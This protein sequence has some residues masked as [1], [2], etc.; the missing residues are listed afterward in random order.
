MRFPISSI[1]MVAI[2]GICFMIY[3]IFNW[4]FN[5][6]GNL[7]DVLSDSANKTMSGGQLTQFQNILPELQQTFGIAC[8]MCFVLAVVFFLV[9]TFSKDG[10]R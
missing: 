2:G 6:P 5:G 9:D 3:I 1:M 4:A 8:V 7:T 10:E